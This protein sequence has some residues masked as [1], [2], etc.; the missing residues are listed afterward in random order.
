MSDFNKNQKDRTYDK[1]T[2]SIRRVAKVTKGGKRLRFSAMVVVGDHNGSVGVGLGRGLDTKSAVE[3]GERI[4][5]K[6]MKKIQLAGDTIPH[7]VFFKEGAAKVILRPARPGTGVIAGSSVRTVLELAGIDNV[8]GKLIG[9]SDAIATAYCTFEA[10][11]SLR[12]GRVL[13]RMRNMRERV[14]TKKETDK[15]RKI[16]EEKIRAKKR[17]EKNDDK[18]SNSRSPRRREFKKREEKK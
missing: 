18:R 4:A 1:K 6:K 10:L 11:K 15:E 14:E 9:T 8:Y 3:K 5:T 7:E 12:N 2:V 16:K 13:A 17:A